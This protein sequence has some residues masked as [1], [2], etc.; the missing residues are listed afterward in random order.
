MRTLDEILAEMPKEKRDEIEDI[1]REMQ[2]EIDAQ[3]RECVS[4]LK[5]SQSDSF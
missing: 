5:N 4:S 1:Y 3:K 2:E